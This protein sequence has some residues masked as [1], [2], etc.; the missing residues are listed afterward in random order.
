VG[1]FNICLLSLKVLFHIGISIY[2]NEIN[3]IKKCLYSTTRQRIDRLQVTIRID[4]CESANS[5]AIDF[6]TDLCN[7]NKNYTLIL[8]EHRLG[9]YGSLNEIFKDSHAKYI[10]QLDADDYL[11]DG[12]LELAM[13]YLKNYPDAGL[14]YTDCI[15]IDEHGTPYGLGHRSQMNLS[16][17]SILVQFITF[18]LRIIKASAFRAVG[19][20]N[21]SLYYAGD[22]DLSLRIYECFEVV[23]I[24]RPLYFYRVYSN[25]TSRKNLDLLQKETFSICSRALL[26]AGLANSYRLAMDI[27]GRMSLFSLEDVNIHSDAVFYISPIETH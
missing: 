26:R 7:K 24:S 2:M 21:D 13:E 12:A 10:C 9:T 19:G 18:H 4:G 5:E 17:L 22:Y 11:A 1:I 27:D 20:F 25:S 15:E 23:H 14:F 8:G 3:H 16:N 6:L